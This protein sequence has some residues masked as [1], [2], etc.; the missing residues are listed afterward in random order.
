MIHFKLCAVMTEHRSSG[1]EAMVVVN[2]LGALGTKLQ[3]PQK[4]STLDH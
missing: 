2:L 4:T 3:V 1:A